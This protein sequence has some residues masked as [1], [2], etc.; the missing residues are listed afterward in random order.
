MWVCVIRGAS[1]QQKSKT[2]YKS[3]RPLT[4]AVEGM[5]FFSAAEMAETWEL[6]QQI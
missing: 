1:G 6:G 4:L 3:K 2:I 5:A